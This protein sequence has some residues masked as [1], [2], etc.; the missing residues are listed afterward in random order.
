MLG[1]VS[2]CGKEDYWGP[3][4]RKQSGLAAHCLRGGSVTRLI[5][6]AM[7]KTATQPPTYTGPMI[8]K[9]L[10]SNTIE[11]IV[12]ERLHDVREN[13]INIL[14][15]RQ[16]LSENYINRT[17]SSIQFAVLS[18]AICEACSKSK[19]TNNQC[20]WTSSTVK[21]YI[22]RFYSETF[23]NVKLSNLFSEYHKGEPT[24]WSYEE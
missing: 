5:S 23:I 12:I 10:W 16:N 13:N 14:T 9:I 15:F 7:W 22:M 24:L 1:W 17:Q 19:S 4:G 20:R 2:E 8:Y 3:C 21:Y 6:A 18:K 11:G